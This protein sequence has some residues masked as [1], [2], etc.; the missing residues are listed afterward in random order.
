MGGSGRPRATID[1][2]LF[3]SGTIFKRGNPF[4]LLEAW[5]AGAFVLLL[6]DAQYAEQTGVFQRPRIVRRH[7]L[8][9]AELSDLFERLA[10]TNRVAATSTLPLRVRHP[11][12]E[13]ILAAALGG[14][15]GYLVTG[16]D[17]LL[18]LAGDPR[19]SDLR[20]V[21]VVALLAALPD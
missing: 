20:I 14:E 17:D 2:N 7:L 15:A 9:A 21:A 19:L 4:S 18:S 5:R 8:T 1:T 10:A 3:V 6:S 11:N 16:D 13:H 12:D